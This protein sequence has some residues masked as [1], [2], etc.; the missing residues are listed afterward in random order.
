MVIPGFGHGD[1]DAIAE[2]CRTRIPDLRARHPPPRGNMCRKPSIGQTLSHSLER[3][4]LNMAARIT[5]VRAREMRHPREAVVAATWDIKGIERTEVKAQAVEVEPS[6]A[7]EGTYQVRGRFA[8]IPWRGRFAYELNPAGFHSRS[9]GV[10]ADDATIEGGF[11]VTPLAGGC[12]VIHYEQYV[13]TL[14]L[15]PLA[16]LIRL[17]L[18]WTM[19]RELC[20]LERVVTKR[21]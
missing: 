14:W 21:C 20:E 17:Y 16:P 10:R 18:R 9:A 19:R 7:T 2:F 15:R 5:V 13:L 1:A 8:G 6:T 4:A 12:T 11:V 3:G